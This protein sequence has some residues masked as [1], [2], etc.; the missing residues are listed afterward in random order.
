LHKYLRMDIATLL[1]T[2]ANGFMAATMAK[3]VSTDVVRQLPYPAMG[4]A[5]ILGVVAGVML[6]RRRQSLRR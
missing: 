5:A 1:Q 4:A 3:R 6:S 2:S